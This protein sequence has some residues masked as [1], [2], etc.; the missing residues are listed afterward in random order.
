MAIK[1]VPAS[2][3][4]PGLSWSLPAKAYAHR[5]PAAVENSWQD[6]S[7]LTDLCRSDC[8]LQ[9]RLPLTAQYTSC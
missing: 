5:V 8:L 7:E 3:R 1:P 2:A 9:W 4:S 6:R